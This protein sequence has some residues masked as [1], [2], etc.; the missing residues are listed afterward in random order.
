MKFKSSVLALSVGIVMGGT[1]IAPDANAG[2]LGSSIFQINDFFLVDSAGTP[3]GNRVTIL[4]D[5]RNGEIAVGLNGINTG[6]TGNAAGSANL[7]IA[8]VLLGA[9]NPALLNNSTAQLADGSGTF[10]RSDLNVSGTVFGVGGQGLTRSDAYALS[11]G[12]E[13]NANSTIA[14]NVLATY[15]ISVGDGGLNNVGFEL[16]AD[17]FL[18]AFVS[19]D[20]FGTSSSAN[21]SISFSIDVLDSNG[22]TVLDWSPSQLNRGVSAF[23]TTGFNDVGGFTAYSNLNSGFF[24]IA[25]GTYTV[26]IQQKST[27]REIAV[28]QVPEPG[29][30]ALLSLGLLGMGAGFRKR[31]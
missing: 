7:D 28:N 27:A 18:K 30:L 20:L 6:K 31:S 2:V 9:S 17:V 14:N 21:A 3:V 10:S 25:S 13:G 1:V 5:N 26:T 8:P 19:P 23:G 15:T 22:N 29:I 12:N 16:D 4:S 11:G 24:N